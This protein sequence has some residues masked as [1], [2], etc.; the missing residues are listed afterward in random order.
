MDIEVEK[1]ITDIVSRHAQVQPDAPALVAEGQAP[2]T[3][4]ALAGLMDRIRQQLN[5][6]GFGRGDRIATIGPNDAST[7]ALVTGIWGCAAAVPMNPAL[8]TGEFAIY[9]RDLQVQAVAIIGGVDTVAGMV[10]KDIGLPVLSVERVGRDVAGMID[11]R[12]LPGGAKVARPGAARGDDLAH[13]LLT[14]GT[15][16]HS[17]VVPITL[18]QLS[19]KAHRY[20]EALELTAADRC[21]NLMP[22]FHGHS[23]QGALYPTLF[24][25]GSIVTLPEFSMESFFRLLATLGPTWYTGS[26][27]FQHA[28]HAAAA[29]HTAEIAN[30]RLRFIRTGS[31]HLDDRI[32]EQLEGFMHTPVI[33]GYSTTE[34][35]CICANPL[36]PRKRKRGTVGLPAGTEVAIVD[37][38]NRPLPPG[39]RG[40]VVVR[41]AEVFS[42]YENDPAANAE[43]FVDGWFRT[44]DE[45]VFD[46]DGYLT[47]TGRIKDIINRGGEKITPSEVDAA[48]MAHPDV[49]TAVTFPVPH[50]TLGQEVAAAVVPEKGA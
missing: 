38:D 39:E 27:T 6:A 48:L 25:G 35:S 4:A 34:T 18:R 29:Q 28:I 24:V 36:P 9:F 5:A 19:T 13:V 30:S 21:L 43:S 37:P 15:T 16:S 44:G 26:Y 7:A 32:A 42:G 14:S 50:T 41:C 12:P 17:K 2:L 33:A 49:A 11:I 40:E 45:G 8:S 10:A 3:Y 47:L 31:G 20:A 22:L 1:T 46:D 23:L